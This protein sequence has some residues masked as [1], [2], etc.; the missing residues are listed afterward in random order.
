M[1]RESWEKFNCTSPSSP[2][3]KRH[4]SASVVV[5]NC[6]LCLRGFLQ[7]HNIPTSCYQRKS[8]KDTPIPSL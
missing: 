6:V 8:D 4:R 7:I 3:K 2:E 5:Y 1:D